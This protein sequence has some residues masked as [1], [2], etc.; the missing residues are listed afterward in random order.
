VVYQTGGHLT[1][2]TLL[3]VKNGN[4]IATAQHLV[5]GIDQL[6]GIVS[7]INN[8]VVSISSRHRNTATGVLWRE[9]LIVTAAHSGKQ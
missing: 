1:V 5:T 2:S 6:A 7:S 4:N 9:G 3:G 8:S